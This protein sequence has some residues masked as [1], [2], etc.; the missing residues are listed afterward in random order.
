MP[1]EQLNRPAASALEIEIFG[2][3]LD[4][5]QIIERTRI[6]SIHREG[7]VFPL[8][9]KLAP[10]A[11]LIVRNPATNEETIARVLGVIH[12]DVCVH[13]YGVVFI[14]SAANPWRVDFPEPPPLKPV[15]LACSRC[16]T[17]EAASL[18][19]IEE[20]IL[21]SRLC[22]TRRCKC[23][24]STTLWKKTDRLP[25]E[26][27]QRATS[28]AVPE[29][30]LP[31]EPCSYEDRRQFKRTAMKA[32]ACIRVSGR[33]VVVQCEDVSRGGFRFKSSESFPVGT[34]FEAA[35]P[36][37]KGSVN[38][39]VPCQVAYHCEL[40]AGSF[41]HGVAYLGVNSTFLSRLKH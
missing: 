18:G 12:D 37:A 5:R 1:L 23:I 31:A 25:P 39:F 4:G 20:K 17:V 7:A 13:V 32:A 27:Q 2:S 41:R 14:D 34:K 36:Y 35:V 26:P 6:I 30:P 8:A 19:E 11:E 28:R 40:W 38:I 33:E 9:H 24:K 10:E 21:E 15:N 22:L 29:P 3:E 16:Q